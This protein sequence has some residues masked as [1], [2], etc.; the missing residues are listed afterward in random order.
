MYSTVKIMK[1]ARPRMLSFHTLSLQRCAR[2]DSFFLGNTIWYVSQD[3]WFHK[4][5]AGLASLILPQLTKSFLLTTDHFIS[6]E[7]PSRRWRQ[8]NKSYPRYAEEAPHLQGRL[9]SLQ[10]GSL[11][12]VPVAPALKV[13]WSCCTSSIKWAAKTQPRVTSSAHHW[14][15]REDTLCQ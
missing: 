5:H 4:Y 11:V 14:D 1:D 2:T 15:W 10:W 9:K 7:K 12:A 6:S 8:H 13:V 3:K